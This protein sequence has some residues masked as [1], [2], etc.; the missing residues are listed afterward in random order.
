MTLAVGLGMSGPRQ[1]P[2]PE[3]LRMT[4]RTITV[5][6]ILIIGIVVMLLRR[7]GDDRRAPSPTPIFEDVER[8]AP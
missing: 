5:I 2:K 3:R 1:D 6:I 7:N 8:I 4:K